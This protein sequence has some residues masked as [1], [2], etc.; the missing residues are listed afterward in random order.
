MVSTVF[1][2]CSLVF[3]NLTAFQ[4][5]RFYEN[6]VLP[7]FRCVRR[8]HF[9]NQQLFQELRFVFGLLSYS[10]RLGL[11]GGRMPV[12]YGIASIS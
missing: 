2:A 11:G 4:D 6:I 5:L 9:V 12:Y 8:W 3:I 10:F 1:E 7:F